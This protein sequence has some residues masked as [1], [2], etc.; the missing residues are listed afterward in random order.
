MTGPSVVIIGAGVVG[1]AIADELSIKGWDDITVIDQG[2]LPKLGGSSSHAPGMVFQHH[3]DRTMSAF[4]QYTV[5][6]FAEVEHEGQTGFVQTGGLEVATTPERL[7]DLRRRHGWAEV[8][9]LE[10]HLLEPEECSALHPLLERSVVLGGLYSPNDGVA[11]AVAAV[12]A[13]L[14]TAKS[15]GVRVLESHTVRDIITEEGAVT[16]VVTEQGEIPAE[17]IVCCA[18]IWGPLVAGLVGDRLPMTT[19]EHQVAW[20][21][22]LSEFAHH[23]AEAT[24][25]MIRHT[26]AGVYYR[27]R[28]ARLE[29]GSF[30]HR[31]IVV[32]PQDILSPDDAPVMPSMHA[33]TPDDFAPQW[34]DTQVVM[35]PTHASRIEGGYN[36][37]MAFTQDDFPLL[38]PSPNVAGLWYAEAVWVTASAG[39]GRAMAEWI[40]DGQSTSFDLSRC[41]L[42]RFDAHQLDSTYHRSQDVTRYVEVY[43]LTHPQDQRKEPRPLRISP[44]HGR[45]CEWGAVFHES[46]GWERPQWYGVNEVLLAE[47]ATSAVPLPE[48]SGWTAQHW[49]PV[50][51]VEAHAARTSAVMVDLTSL[52]RID[53]RGRDAQKLLS[54][55]TTGDMT[56]PPGSVTYC[57]ML[58]A[59]G[60]IRSDVTVTRLADDWFRV[61]ANG[62]QDEAWLREQ[63]RGAA[64]V[65]DDVTPGTCCIGLWGPEAANVL[66]TVPGGD[67]PDIK[68]LGYFRA[69][70]A[71]L[72]GTPVVIQRVSYIGE[73]GWEITTTSDMGLHLWD[74]LSSAGRPHGLIPA[75]HGAVN[76]LRL[77][78]GYRAFGKDMTTEHTPAEAGLAFALRSRLEHIGSSPAGASDVGPEPSDEAP[79]T[80]LVTLTCAPST[81]RLLGGEPVYASDRSAALGYVGSA[82]HGYSVGQGIATAWVPSESATTGTELII[83]AYDRD[84]P[85]V[86][87]ETPVVP[88]RATDPTG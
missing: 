58:N 72:A 15:R 20:T 47:T 80:R 67:D 74:A 25:P 22:P 59:A 32:D 16:G 49:S 76:A 79:G 4:A 50:V 43:D 30:A 78:V 77:E 88:I 62:A 46:S 2:R 84:I 41:E 69:M 18:G 87:T 63:A 71:R 10:T 54:H 14:A 86:V 29:I 24:L 73:Y 40:I 81:V 26:D 55:V 7:A 45:Q 19:V 64:V 66:Q 37:L 13:Q 1:A 38:G 82:D 27:D 36:G 31:P 60:R 8:N 48:Y 33:F 51:A 9:G 53:V 39:V 17:I 70:K 35:P 5:N 34:A 28:F 56:K 61:G 6:K 44:F 11:R 21:E 65:I 52:R 23:T 3:A 42:S 75:G 57:L 12:N 83:G 85:A 68:S